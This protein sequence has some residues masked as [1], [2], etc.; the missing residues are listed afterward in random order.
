MCGEKLFGV[1]RSRCSVGSP[2][3]V[4]GKVKA[5]TFRVKSKG[6]TPACAGKRCRLFFAGA[7][8]RDHP[9]MCGEKIRI[10]SSFFFCPGSPPHVRG[11]VVSIHIALFLAR[12][13]PACAGKRVKC[14]AIDDVFEDHPRMCG[15]K[16]L[17]F[18]AGQLIPG[19]PPHVRGKVKA[20]TFRVK[21]KGITPACAGKR[22]RL[23]FA[24]AC[25]RDH[26]RM[27]GEKRFPAQGWRCKVGSPP[28]VRGKEQ[29]RRPD[30]PGIGIT[31]ACAGKRIDMPSFIL[32]YRDH[33]RMCGEKPVHRPFAGTGR[34]SP[35]HVRGK[36]WKYSACAV[37]GRITP[38]CA[39]KSRPLSGFQLYSWD[40]P[41]MCGEK[42][43]GIWLCT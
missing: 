17:T 11:K 22:C 26:P 42:K 15:E 13:T 1:C 23:F 2:P 7:C 10:M 6:I 40:H 19:S 24:G 18:D 34:G 35:P 5:S 28:H 36:G 43:Q 3:H 32:T 20:S 4:R 31:P 9:R 14:R 29:G 38:A 21:S 39:G 30:L 41:R 37:N 25:N 33:P 27:C 8:N 16:K 12:I